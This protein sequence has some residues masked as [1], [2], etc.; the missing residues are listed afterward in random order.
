VHTLHRRE[1]SPRPV[2]VHLSVSDLAA[3]GVLRPYFFNI[4]LP[5]FSSYPFF[6]SFVLSAP[7][8]ISLFFFYI[9]VFTAIVASISALHILLLFLDLL[10]LHQLYLHTHLPSAHVSPS[11]QLRLLHLW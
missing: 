5:C 8:F 4:I 7:F 2:D 10:T 1:L 6:L 3:A 9:S 11:P